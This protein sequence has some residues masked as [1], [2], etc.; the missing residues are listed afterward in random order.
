MYFRVVTELDFRMEHCKYITCDT[1]VG[2]YERMM[3]ASWLLR[4]LTST[5]LMKAVVRTKKGSYISEITPE[6]EERFERLVLHY[7]TLRFVMNC[8]LQ[9]EPLWRCLFGHRIENISLLRPTA[10]KRA[11]TSKRTAFFTVIFFCGLLYQ[12]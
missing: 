11:S 6:R 2:G 5:G 8:Y 12:Y 9:C 1:I 3:K 10:K 4:A 7:P